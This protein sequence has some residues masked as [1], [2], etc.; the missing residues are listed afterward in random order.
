MIS[1]THQHQVPCALLLLVSLIGLGSLI[2]CGRGSSGGGQFQVTGTIFGFDRFS[3]NFG[4]SGSSGEAPF[5]PQNMCLQFTFSQPLNPDSVS[6]ESI[7]VQ[8]ITENPPGPGPDAGVT[9][10][11]EGNTLVVCPLI[12]FS[13]SNVTFGFEPSRTYQLLFQLPPSKTVVRSISGQPLREADRG[14]YRFKTNTTIFD[15]EKGPPV[16]T[17]SLLDAGSGTSLDPNLVPFKPVPSI[18]IDF[19]ESVIPSTVVSDAASGTSNSLSVSLDVDGNPN[20]SGDR[21]PLP[22]RFELIQDEMSAQVNWTSLLTELPTAPTTCLY[23][24]RIGGTVADIAGNSKV[25][26]ENDPLAGD[27]MSFF[28]LPGPSVGQADPVMEDFSVTANSDSVTSARWGS[29]VPGFLTSGVGGGTGGDGVFDPLDSGFPPLPLQSQ[30]TVDSGLKLVTIETEDQANLGNVRVY[31][32]LSIVIPLDW[33]VRAQG[34]FP[35]ELLVS[36]DVTIRGLLDVSGTD[37][38]S[39]SVGQVLPGAGGVAALGGASG[40]IGGSLT[41]GLGAA[42]LFPGQGGASPLYGEYGFEDVAIPAS[43]GISGRITS[44]TDFSFTD[45]SQSLTLSTIF[46]DLSNIWVQPNVGADDFRFERFH[47]AFKV[48]LIS[49]PAFSQVITVVSDS[50]DPDYRGSMIAET[51]NPYLEDVGGGLLR[52]PLLGEMGDAY[53]IGALAGFPGSALFDIDGDG[54]QDNP[55]SYNA[56]RGSEPQAV[57]QTFSTLARAGGGG[58]GG[59]VGAGQ[60]GADDPTVGD[61]PGAFGEPEDSVAREALPRRPSSLQPSWIRRGSA[62]RLTSSTMA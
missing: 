25:L 46:P 36:G 54:M 10:T 50:S 56:G 13:D 41:D 37:A 21:V 51:S 20:T 8:E 34:S 16:P 29:A 59:A 2:G 47:T 38:P 12:T 55:S 53:V 17:V 32:F 42:T 15:R 7:V 57:M 49:G 23:I 58:G 24:V 60:D 19:N 28:T 48:E 30:I 22:G 33:T 31:E 14:P 44:L 26:E 5:I 18:Q 35:L 11:V 62:F 45:T 27:E 6:T 43:R 39:I 61:G 4:S 3:T 40:G 1:R 9:F 52:P